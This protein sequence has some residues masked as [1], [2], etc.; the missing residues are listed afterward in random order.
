MDTI[1][2]LEWRYAVKKFDSNQLLSAEKVEIL[3]N[4]FNLTATS[5]GLQPIKLVI[6]QNKELQNKLVDHSYG[7]QQVGQASHLFIICIE[8]KIDK[9]FIHNYFNRVKQ[10]RNTADE[11]LEPFQGALVDEFSKK[12]REEVRVWAT[13]QAYLALGTLLTVCA[14]EGIDSCPMEG[15]DPS[16]YDKLLGLEKDKLTSVLILPVGYRA[17]DDM[18]AT[19]KKVRKN[20]KDSIIHIS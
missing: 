6:I 1:K 10:I 20:L 3:E 12:E 7:Q 2:K 5:F 15:F 8:K 19:F 9:E 18:F 14:M 13:N 16:A 17:K 4:A 11:I